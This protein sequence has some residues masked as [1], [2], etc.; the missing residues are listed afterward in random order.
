MP[1]FYRADKENGWKPFLFVWKTE[2][3]SEE[4]LADFVWPRGLL[5]KT[6]KVRA[7]ERIGESLQSFSDKFVFGAYFHQES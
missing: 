4:H 5:Q 6:S 7:I 2:E 1:I 3:D